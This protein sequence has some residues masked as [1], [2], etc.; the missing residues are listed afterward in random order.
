MKRLNILLGMLA[1][2]A[3]IAAVVYWASPY[4]P[5]IEPAGDIEALW[6]IEDTREESWDPLV[7]RLENNGVPMGY[8]AALNTFYCPLGMGNGDAWP[9]IR[10]TAPDAQGVRMIFSDDYTYDWCADAIRDAYPYE[11]MAYTDTHYAY[12]YIVFTAL[13]QIRITSA[14][15]ITT[16]DSPI[17]I[18][19]AAYGEEAL[20]TTGRI[21]LRGAST[22]LFDKRGYKMEFTRECNGSAK[23]I[24]LNAPGFGMA[25]DIALL[26]CWHDDS[27]IRDKLNWDLH[28][29]I[30]EDDESFGART[31]EYTEVF[32]NDEYIGLYL[33]IEPVDVQEEIALSGEDR[34]MTDSVYRTAAL[35]FSRDR[36]YL[37]H[38]KRA[39]AGY[40]LY[41]A[42][43]GAPKFAGMDAYIDLMK[44]E[45]DEEFARKALACMDMDSL[46]D[47]LLF[48][49]GAGIS[50]NFFNNM[51]IWAHPT[52]DGVTYKFSCW[53]LDMA[54]GFEKDEIGEEFEN[55][56]YFPIADRMINLDVGGIRQKLY[57]RW[58]ELRATIFSEER[59]EERITR[60][61]EL[62]G[63]S[64][65]LMRDA[66]KWQTGVGYPDG[67]DIVT[68][69][70]LRWP[71]LDR[72]IELIA[73]NGGEPVEFLTSSHYRGM[74]G[75]T[76]RI[77]LGEQTEE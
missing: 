12:F 46:L 72:A 35:N 26:P 45:D 43:Q 42:P 68:F 77:A 39:N 70:G 7:T 17:R 67:Y 24:E 47:H 33:M 22:L 10:L 16:E 69:S 57:D 5:V 23:K 56:L 60:Y 71:I 49:Q 66:E 51:Y 20:R 6:A 50:D 3:V 4:A 8:D 27:K 65:A 75:G 36:E 21:H 76:M 1:L 55:W 32:L 62:I 44:E 9:E 11:V 37:S 30:Y 13:P 59:L 52:Q 18:E 2:A 29:E 73:T 38:P 19:M 40:E 74:K 34:L 61:Q 64:G 31:A 28:A 15:E 53:D 58:Q 41:Y 14:Q 48:V 54:W 63:D 25:D